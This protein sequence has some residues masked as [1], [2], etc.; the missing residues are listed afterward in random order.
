MTSEANKALVR[1]YYGEVM[2]GGRLELLPELVAPGFRNHGP[3][4]QVGGPEGLARLI[5]GFRAAL[6]DLRVTVE[7][8]VAEGDL[9]ST[10]W[11]ARGTHRGTLLGIPATG[12]ALEVTAT[13]VDRIADGRIVERWA[14][15]DD[16][17]LLRQLGLVPS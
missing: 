6:P 8:I 17:G 4:G 5:G 12:K 15:Q 2:D 11:R 9:V 13:V 1:R 7:Q 3:S 14:N 10:R 16:L